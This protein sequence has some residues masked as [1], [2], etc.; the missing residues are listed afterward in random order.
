SA[1]G[2]LGVPR[3]GHFYERPLPE[4]TVVVDGGNPQRSSRA[5]LGGLVLPA[6]AR[7]LDDQ[8]QILVTD[9]LEPDTTTASVGWSDARE[10]V[11]V[12]LF[13]VAVQ[14]VANREVKALIFHVRDNFRHLFQHFG[15]F[16]FPRSG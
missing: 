6:L 16:L 9:R 15:Q 1:D 11:R 4:A 14:R 5:D 3:I 8:I 7:N 12:V 13:F 2:S 10:K